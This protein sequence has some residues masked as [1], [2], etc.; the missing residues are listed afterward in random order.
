[1]TRSHSFTLALLLLVGISQAKP[2]SMFGYG[3]GGENHIRHQAGMGM[4]FYAPEDRGCAMCRN[5]ENCSIAV[6]NQSAGVFCGDV[7]STFQPCCCS[8]RN[9]CMTSIFSDSCECFDGAREEQIMTTRFYL[10]VGLSLIAWGLLAYDKMCAGPYKVMNSNHQ[11]LANSPSVARARGEE[12]VVDT[13]DSDSDDEQRTRDQNA[14]SSATAVAVAASAVA[15]DV[16]EVEAEVDN[17]TTPLRPQSSSGEAT[18]S[19][20]A[21]A[22]GSHDETRTN[23]ER[24]SGSTSIQTV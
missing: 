18:E 21:E 13:V 19:A 16:A 7:L 22:D 14:A 4:E 10:F 9:E 1:M 6:H 20:D 11:I 5:G 23:S 3:Y 8:Y 17:D 24:Q 2:L 12:S 15:V